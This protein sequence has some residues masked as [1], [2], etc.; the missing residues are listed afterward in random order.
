MLPK[1]LMASP[2][3]RPRVLTF[4]LYNTDL[5]A[6]YVDV[7][8]T[9]RPTLLIDFWSNFLSIWQI[10][11][12]TTCLMLNKNSG[13]AGWHLWWGPWIPTSSNVFHALLVSGQ[14]GTLPSPC[15]VVWS[16]LFKINIIFSVNNLFLNFTLIVVDSTVEFNTKSPIISFTCFQSEM[17]ETLRWS[18]RIDHS[19]NSR[20]MASAL[21]ASLIFTLEGVGF[22]VI[23]HKTENIIK[24]GSLWKTRWRSGLQRPNCLLKGQ[25]QTRH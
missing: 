17:R 10:G 19:N 22:T 11:N 8:A 12:A 4:D 9:I 1:P 2:R 15:N 23:V 25:R 13:Q 24:T 6:K 3:L 20:C 14:H 7:D 16:K 5:N 18:P 21:L